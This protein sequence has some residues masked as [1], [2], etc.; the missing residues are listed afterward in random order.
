M[1]TPTNRLGRLEPVDLREVWGS[2][3]GDFTLAQDNV[4]R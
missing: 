3:S 4:R 2:E 1:T